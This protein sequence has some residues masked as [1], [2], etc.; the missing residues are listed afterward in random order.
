MTFMQ[1]NSEHL[2]VTHHID[3]PMFA[4]N[5]NRIAPQRA[6]FDVGILCWVRPVFWLVFVAWVIWPWL[7]AANVAYERES[8]RAVGCFQSVDSGGSSETIKCS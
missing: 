8:R 1:S 2:L 4:S 3:A 7:V 6:L 5:S